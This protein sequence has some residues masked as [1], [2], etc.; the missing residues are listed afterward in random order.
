MIIYDCEIVCG[1]LGKKDKQLPMIKYAKGWDDYKGMGISVIGCFDYREDRYRVFCR[2]NFGDFQR[3]I[4]TRDIVVGFNNW[5]FDDPLCKAHGI[6]I[7][8]S[9][10]YDILVEVWK[11]A[12]FGPKFV[13]P[14][15]AGYSL[16]AC[17]GTNR[18]GLGKFGDGAMAPVDWQRG[19]IG[20]VID[21]CLGDVYLTREL[22]EMII[23]NGSIKDPKTGKMIKVRS[24]L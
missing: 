5:S 2:D 7:A 14:T 21:Y 24:P 12:G 8:E 20:K 10:S 1:I 18:P 16:G 22:L 15:H 13:Y 3:L 4:D 6:E 23:N 17:I 19:N 9:K 11:G